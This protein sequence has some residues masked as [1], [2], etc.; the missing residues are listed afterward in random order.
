M[1]KESMMNEA[2]KVFFSA[3]GNLGSSGVECL[4]CHTQPTQGLTHTHTAKCQVPMLSFAS[5]AKGTSL[6]VAFACCSPSSIFRTSPP[7]R[8]VLIA[9]ATCKQ[10]FSCTGER[11]F[12]GA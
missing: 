8:R 6:G 12:R 7:Q 2:A 3:S 10:S 1:V 9:A 11:D 4:G 5:L